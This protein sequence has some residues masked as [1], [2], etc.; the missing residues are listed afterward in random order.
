MRSRRS[1]AGIAS[2]HGM[3][4]TSWAGSLTSPWWSLSRGP[5]TAT[6]SWRRSVS[7]AGSGWRKPARARPPA[8]HIRGGQ[9]Q[10]RWLELLELQHD[11]LHAALEWS[12]SRGDPT[13]LQVAVSAA[14]F[15]Y[16]HGHWDEARRSLERSIAVEGA[17]ST[18][19]AR[20]FAWTGVFA[21]RRGDLD[22]ARESAEA[23]LRLLSGTGDEGEG[24]S[25]LV[26]SL[27]GISS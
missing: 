27:V 15:W 8:P 11:D 23:S 5:R 4:S 17:E 26:L 12:W 2:K 9:H 18:L 10:A 7:T 13:S 1:V 16:L 14:W 19:Q 6:G 3:S 25:L 22:H 21:W 24:L 20:G